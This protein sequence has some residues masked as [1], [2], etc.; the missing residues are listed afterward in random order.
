MQY[1]FEPIAALIKWTFDNLLV[2][3][4]DLPGLLNPNTIFTI[5]IGL[6]LLYWLIMQSK[7][8]KKAE[9]EGGIK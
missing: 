9:K 7:Y 2:P 4:G 5:L 6:G 3:I 8:N 1:I